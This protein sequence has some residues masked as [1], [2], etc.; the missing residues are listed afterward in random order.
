MIR[1]VRCDQPQFR[2]VKFE[3]GL[4]VIL[5][6]RTEESTD[7]DSRNGLG[8]T[9]LIEIINF[10]LGSNVKKGEG[11][12]QEPVLGWTYSLDL[13]LRGLPY[14]VSRNTD[15]PS[16]VYTKGD[17]SGWPVVPDFDSD[18]GQAWLP[19]R[20]W[21]RV[22]G[23]LV[24]DLPLRGADEKYFPTFRSLISYFVR[25]GRDAFSNPFRHY[26]IQ[27]A[28]DQQVNNAFLLGLGWEYAREWQFLRVRDN[29]L[30]GLKEAAKGGI[31]TDV[32]GTLGE[33]DADRFRLEEQIER[34][35]KQ[36]D[37]FQVHPQY[38]RIEEEA[39][40]LTA[41]IHEL[42]NRNIECRRML[43]FY[44][45]S[46]IEEQPASPDMVC[47]VYEQAGVVLP[48]MVV[49]RLEEVQEFHRRISVNRRQFLKG[50]IDRLGASIDRTEDRIGE[51]AKERAGL[52]SILKTHGALKEY[53][54]LQQA[55][56][57]LVSELEETK[58][59]LE[60]LKKL[61]KEKS[62][63]KIEKEQ[64]FQAA[65]ADNEER[66]SIR[67][68]AISLFDANSEALYEVPGKL[69]VDIDSK[70]GFQFQ[71]E[72]ERSGS[73]G[74]DQMK[75]FCYD[76]MLAQLWSRGAAG[77]GFLVHDSTIFDGVDERQVAKALQLAARTSE[78][79]GFQYVCCLNSDQ[80]PNTDFDEGFNLNSYVRLT[81][82]DATEDGGL[83][84][85][86]F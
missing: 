64:L 80:I 28:W 49:R 62:A 21:N 65:R 71:V 31:L 5:A 57:Q 18:T 12:H 17:C 30:K 72:I 2:T 86:R 9:T 45:S 11:L 66:E 25:E 41:E 24:F 77:P 54:E 1:S 6:E 83:L 84:G 60:T 44:D 40:S 50:E 68:R 23:W 52:L 67:G 69:I 43:G 8:K 61:E 73:Q 10:C 56:T 36:L 15:K 4:N 55:F 59:R 78:E 26:P 39:T 82:T 42:T 19:A 74:I 37:T 79:F 81:L 13:D 3:Q 47:D 27:Q 46:L 14:T 63:I 85:I 38:R 53:T 34:Q 22:Q 33:L 48:G 20:Q 7:K 51:L 35:R 16:R 29:A 76:L 70:K 75:V 58:N 32:L